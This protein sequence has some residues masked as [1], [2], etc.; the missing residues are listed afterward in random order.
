[1]GGRGSGQWRRP[2]RKALVEDC[3]HLDVN[4]WHREGYLVPGRQFRWSWWQ[5]GERQSSIDV[6]ARE[7]AVELAYTLHPG[8]ERA[9][10]VRYRVALTWTPCTFGGRRTWFRCPGVVG[11]RPCGRRVAKLYLADRYFLCR[12]CLDLSY[13]T[14]RQ[15]AAARARERAQAIRLRLGGSANLLKRFPWKPLRMRW[16]TY[17]RLRQEAEAAEQKSWAA[18]AARLG[19]AER[20]VDR[21]AARSTDGK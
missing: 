21:I 4:R 10:G 6:A 12:Q 8:T 9:E 20:H 18:V 3:W 19:L 5:G 7:E 17:W 1:V 11:G 2:D 15:D 13:R 14:R 16:R